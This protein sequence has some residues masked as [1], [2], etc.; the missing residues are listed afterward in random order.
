MEAPEQVDPMPP[1]GELINPQ[2][3]GFSEVVEAALKTRNVKLR[4]HDCGMVGMAGFLIHPA[5]IVSPTLVQGQIVLSAGLVC[6]KCGAMKLFNTNV[7]GIVM[8][9]AEP[10]RVITPDQI[11][12]QAP[13]LVMP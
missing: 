2:P 6:S 10:S 5:P 1:P 9:Q 12:Q 13:P 3:L 4:C 11:R 8:Q 7:L